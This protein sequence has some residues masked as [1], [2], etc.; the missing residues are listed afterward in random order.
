MKYTNSVFLTACE[1]LLVT[2]NEHGD[3]CAILAVVKDLLGIETA[4]IKSWNKCSLEQW[5]VCKWAIDCI[6]EVGGIDKSR[7]EE[8]RK[9]VRKERVQIMRL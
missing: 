7:R 1:Q 9:L 8:R 5:R 4:G 2:N 3:S 6:W